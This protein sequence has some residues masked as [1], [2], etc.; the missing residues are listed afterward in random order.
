MGCGCGGRKATRTS[1]VAAKTVASPSPNATRL[2]TAQTFQSATIRKA[3]TGP[4]GAGRKT[5]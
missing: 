5:V 1:G 4:V 3:P 2:E